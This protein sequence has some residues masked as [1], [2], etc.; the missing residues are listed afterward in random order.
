MVRLTLRLDELFERLTLI[1]EIT[2]RLGRRTAGVDAP[3]SA[4]ASPESFISGLRALAQ[5]IARDQG[6]SVEVLGD[7]QA[8]DLLPEATAMELR[9]VAVQLVRNAVSHGIETPEERQRA[10]K[11][12]S[13]MVYIGC[14]EGRAGTV[15]FVLRDDG[16]GVSPG[17]I[18][19]A[20]VNSGRFSTEQASALADEQVIRKIFEPGLSTAESADL[21][22]GRGVGMDLVWRKVSELGA[23]LRLQTQAD[24]YTQFT[25][26][27]DRPLRD[28]K[29]P[30]AGTAR[31]QAAE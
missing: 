9:S 22:A 20:L 12:T 6:K 4:T 26:S 8:L 18:R 19:Q 3:A 14:S 25:L 21:H 17:R 7:L 16:R 1:R 31:L 23:R 13:G 24:R 5:R 2:E 30:A 27:L 10:G 11:P 28:V 15:E 29:W